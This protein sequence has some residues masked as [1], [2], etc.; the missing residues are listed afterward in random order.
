M[1]SILFFSIGLSRVLFLDDEWYGPILLA[2]LVVL[3][4]V[5]QLGA[6][7]ISLATK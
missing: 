2:V 6:K 1:L 3:A 4:L 5:I 7:L